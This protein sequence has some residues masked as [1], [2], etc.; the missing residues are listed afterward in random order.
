MGALRLTLDWMASTFY[1]LPAIVSCTLKRYC[2]R[3]HNHY[4]WNNNIFCNCI[5]WYSQTHRARPILNLAQ[6][7]PQFL[8]QVTILFLQNSLFSL[9][10][11]E[12]FLSLFSSLD[13]NTYNASTNRASDPGIFDPIF[14]DA[15]THL[16]KKICS[17]VR[18]AV[19]ITRP[20]RPT[21]GPHDDGMIV[22]WCDYMRHDYLRSKPSIF[23]FLTKAWPTDGPT[24]R[25]TDVRTDGQ[26][27]L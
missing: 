1:R 16:K 6:R 25:P 4:H 26:T 2:L 17:F 7:Q 3:H 23:P 10:H 14:L 21:M 18:S 8:Q 5:L 19:L 9:F 15:P 22:W 24:D 11:R 12:S 20:I 27:R 13:P